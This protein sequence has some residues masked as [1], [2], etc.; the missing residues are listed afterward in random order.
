MGFRNGEGCGQRK[1]LGEGKVLPIPSTGLV[2]WGECIRILALVAGLVAG[3]GAT[4]VTNGAIAD[5]VAAG[6]FT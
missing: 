6:T 5:G 1:R 3:G 4:Q 2:V